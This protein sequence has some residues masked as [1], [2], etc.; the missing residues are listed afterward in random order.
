[1]SDARLKIA[2]YSHDAV[3]LGHLR[4]NLLIAQTLRERLGA[5][6]LMVS[7]AWEGGLFELA[8]GIDCV[9]LPALKKVAEGR[10]GSRRLDVPY[11][12][13]IRLRAMTIDAAIQVFKPDLFVT[14]K[15]PAGVGGELVPALHRLRRE[16]HARCVLGLRDILDD[17][18]TVR[19]EWREAGYVG[20]IDDYYDAVWVYGDPAVYD[21]VGEYGFPA[22]LARKVVYTG[23]LSR[24]PASPPTRCQVADALAP[25]RLPPGRIALC[26]VGG[27]QDGDVLA[28]AFAAATLPEGTNGLI[29][30]GPFM[31]AEARRALLRASVASERLRVLE[32]TSDTASLLMAADRVVTMGGYNAVCEVLSYHKRALIVPR[33]RPRREQL[34][35]AMRLE[36]LGLL[37]VLHPDALSPAAI[38][39]WLAR[40]DDGQRA[41]TMGAAVDFTGLE[42]LP[43]LVRAARSIARP[44]EAPI[45]VETRVSHVI[46]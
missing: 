35:R 26:M 42:R 36:Q 11:A 13:L 24:R 18:T 23:Y 38:S 43:E 39:R 3:G 16:G 12:D 6:V 1:M 31:P 17:P 22:E 10:Y 2:M 41:D 32:F 14:D 25:L 7:G 8:D 4:R 33:V 5:T 34:V 44:V 46:G 40:E 15:V 29:L 21:L 20:V 28:N 27:G 37:D 19:R 9:T 30:T 45:R